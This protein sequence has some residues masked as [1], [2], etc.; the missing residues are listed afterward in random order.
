MI[1]SVI[2][3][4]KTKHEECEIKKNDKEAIIKM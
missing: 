1:K 2:K 3:L 4:I